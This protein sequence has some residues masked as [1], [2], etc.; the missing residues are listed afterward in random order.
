M[1]RVTHAAVAK[2]AAAYAESWSVQ[3]RSD[4]AGEGPLAP[5]IDGV[6]AVVTAAWTSPLVETSTAAS[7]DQV[8][9]R[10]SVGTPPR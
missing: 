9:A 7:I 2:T 10:T 4:T 6:D 3:V 1:P 5:A 8:E